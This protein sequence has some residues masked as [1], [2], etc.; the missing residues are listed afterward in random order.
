[1]LPLLQSFQDFFL[2]DVFKKIFFFFKVLESSHLFVLLV[3]DI[4]VVKFFCVI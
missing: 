3:L 4:E 2:A 1:M